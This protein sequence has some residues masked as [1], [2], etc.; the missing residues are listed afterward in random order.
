MMTSPRPRRRSRPRCSRG[1]TLIELLVVIAIIALLVGILLPA[2]GEAR[3]AGR[4]TVCQGNMKQM[5]L[6]FT[7][8]GADFNNRSPSFSWNVREGF[9][10]TETLPWLRPLHPNE[11]QAAARQAVSIMRNRAERTDIQEITGW[12][13]HVLYSHLILNDY[14]Q[15]RLPEPMVVCPEDK[16][17]L[18]WHDTVRGKTATAARAAFLALPL[19]QR[20]GDEANSIQRWP[21]S[22]SYNYITAAYSLDMRHGSILT[23]ESSLQNHYTYFV[24]G[25]LGK[26]SQ[27]EVAFPAN[28]VL[29]YDNFGRHFGKRQLWFAYPSIAQ[30]LLFADASTSA[31]RRPGRL[32]AVSIPTTPAVRSP[33]VIRISLA[34]GNCRRAMAHPASW[35]PGTTSGA[36]GVCAVRITMVKT[37]TPVS[38]SKRQIE[39]V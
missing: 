10:A 14:L 12:I 2:L 18:L 35:S 19:T 34:S 5:G 15:Q 3:K 9:S 20:P 1:F 32:T 39:Y 8:Y 27:D 29:M 21:Y 4:M 37:S 24:N 16:L 38:R 11:L 6:A 22:C 25:P 26:R 36:A 13:P 33:L 7:S 28:K 17:R 31:S 30:P 23:V